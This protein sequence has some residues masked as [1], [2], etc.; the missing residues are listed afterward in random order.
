MKK[1]N[2]SLRKLLLAVPSFLLA[3]ALLSSCKKDTNNNTPIPVSALMAFNLSPDKSAVGVAL[4]GNLLTNS[5]LNYTNYT[6]GYR[7]IYPGERSVQSYDYN[8][9]TTLVTAS[10]NFEDQRYYSLFVVGNNGS[11]KTVIVKDEI[12]SLSST[13]AYVRYI[14]AIP[15]SNALSVT[16]S[17]NGSDIVNTVAPFSSVS[18]FTPVNTG[19]VSIAIANGGGVFANRTIPVE[20]GK[21]YTVLLLGVPSATDTTKAVQIKYILNGTISPYEQE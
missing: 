2:V 14:N 9:D 11:Y 20:N 19:Y 18:S 4:S 10:F 17:A 3:A 5:P 7:N 21:I 12:D 8:K 15:D 1:P 6:S 13:H 16:V